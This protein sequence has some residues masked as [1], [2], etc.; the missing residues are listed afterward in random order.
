[1]LGECLP[2]R[3]ETRNNGRARCDEETARPLVRKAGCETNGERDPSPASGAT[4]RSVQGQCIRQMASIW[5]ARRSFRKAS[6][7]PDRKKRSRTGPC[8]PLGTNPDGTTLSPTTPHRWATMY[9]MQIVLGIPRRT[10]FS[11]NGH[12]ADVATHTSNALHNN[13]VA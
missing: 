1:M 13:P 10:N 8:E 6:P 9:V 4:I 11:K 2:H 3:T 7:T 5:S 12:L